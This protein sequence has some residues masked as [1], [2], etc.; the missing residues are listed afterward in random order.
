MAGNIER[1]M[2][3]G[4]QALS[5]M[6]GPKVYDFPKS[7]SLRVKLERF[8]GNGVLLSEGDEH[9]VGSTMKSGLES[10]LTL[11]SLDATSW[12]FARSSISSH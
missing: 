1:V 3:V 2:V 8:T 6:M 5:E 11:S 7:E 12:S 9:K 4:S 10:I